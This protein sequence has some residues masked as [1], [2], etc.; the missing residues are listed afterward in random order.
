MGRQKKVD[1]GADI[2]TAAAA[3]LRRGTVTAAPSR[4]LPV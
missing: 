4:C 3:C 1:L 2:G